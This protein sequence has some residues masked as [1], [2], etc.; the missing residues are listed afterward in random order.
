VANK[1][2][3]IVRLGQAEWIRHTYPRPAGDALQLLG[4]VRR[5][6]Q[7][8]ALA[9][10]DTGEYVQVVGDFV[11]PLNSKKI[12]LALARTKP[13]DVGAAARAPSK[14]APVPVVTIKRRRIPLLA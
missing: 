2:S 1:P 13:T 6:M 5:G 4:S 3:W 8:G 10:T 14:S 9:K 7:I 12:E 11:T